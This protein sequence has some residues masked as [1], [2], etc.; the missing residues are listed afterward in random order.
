MLKLTALSIP[1]E[2][3]LLQRDGFNILVDSGCNSKG[4]AQCFSDKMPNLEFIHVAVCT[5]A[6]SDHARGFTKILEEWKPQNKDARPPIGE[7]WLPR[8]WCDLFPDLMS[9]EGQRD[10]AHAIVD[11]MISLAD[12]ILEKMGPNFDRN[13]NRGAEAIIESVLA[14]SKTTLKRPRRRG[15]EVLQRKVMKKWRDRSRK[16]M[17]WLIMGDLTLEDLKDMILHVTDARPSTRAIA[18]YWISLASAATTIRDIILSAHHHNVKIRWFDFSKFEKAGRPEGGIPDLLTPINAVE[19]YDPSALF[20]QPPD[21]VVS[22]RLF[23]TLTNAQCLSFYSPGHSARPGVLFCGD[24]PMGYG[25]KHLVPFKLPGRGRI[26]SVIA[27]APHHGQES[28][29][30][31]YKHIHHQVAPGGIFWIRSGG[32][33]KNPPGASFCGIPSQHRICTWCP[34]SSAGSPKE[35]A[36]IVQPN[37]IGRAPIFWTGNRCSCLTADKVGS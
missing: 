4:L 5:H 31:A 10:L 3:L 35:V 18:R 29:A 6:D 24:S 22:Y 30:I 36:T 27:T 25:R 13:P 33:R 37:S 2:A 23:L 19:L 21:H 15:E 12:A 14:K 7:F 9:R 32:N 16:F 26:Q 28:N 17:N 1:G 34:Y 11:D 8:V 20:Q